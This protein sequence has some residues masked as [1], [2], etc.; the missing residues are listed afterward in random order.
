MSR[1]IVV[2]IVLIAVFFV[3]P[4]L[5]FLFSGTRPEAC[6]I[7][8]YYAEGQKKLADILAGELKYYAGNNVTVCAAKASIKKHYVLPDIL[9]KPAIARKLRLPVVENS[10]KNGL[11]HVDYRVSAAIAG[12]IASKFGLKG[13]VFRDHASV[14]IYVP[15]GTKRVVFGNMTGASLEAYIRSRL[16]PIIAETIDVVEINIGTLPGVS[17]YPAVLV[18]SSRPLPYNVGKR[19]SSERPVYLLS[20][21]RILGTIG[22]AV[23]VAKDDVPSILLN[24]PVYGNR[25]ATRVIVVGELT[26]PFTIR[27]WNSTV[28]PYLE[29]LAEEGKIGLSFVPY[30]VHR[31]QGILGVHYALLERLSGSDML[32]IELLNKIFGAELRANSLEEASKIARSIIGSE[33]G[34]STA[35]LLSEL[36]DAA[37]KVGI[38]GVPATIVVPVQGKWAYIILG[39]QPRTFV[40][41]VLSQ[42]LLS[43]GNK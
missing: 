34:N 11:L 21:D 22:K 17:R 33:H 32:D 15:P 8:V 6:D 18:Y 30:V 35:G 1:K 4:L 40:E 10:S 38:Y 29:R 42:L 7:I 26:C 3:V 13:P 36:M 2:A 14:V 19:V 39:A 20:S 12:A 41:S 43:Q 27:Y 5:G 28:R 24:Q 23:V 37:N 9:V 25:S 16:E 31:T